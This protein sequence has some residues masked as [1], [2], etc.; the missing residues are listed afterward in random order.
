MYWQIDL[1]FESLLCEVQGYQAFSRNNDPVLFDCS[2][3]INLLVELEN[4]LFPYWGLVLV[5]NLALFNAEW[6]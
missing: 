4:T 6:C 5:M 3:C 2:Q 1:F